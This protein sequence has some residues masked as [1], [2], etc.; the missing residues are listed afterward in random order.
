MLEEAVA[1]H[2]DEVRLLSGVHLGRQSPTDG[3]QIY[4]ALSLSLACSDEVS[5]P[6]HFA[7][8]TTRQ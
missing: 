5:A 1:Q 6:Y 7:Q 8:A 2:R 4:S 3:S